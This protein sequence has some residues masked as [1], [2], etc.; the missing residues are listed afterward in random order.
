VY[1]V[2]FYALSIDVW[3]NVRITEGLYNGGLDNRDSTVVNIRENL[4]I[5]PIIK[6]VEKNIL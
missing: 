5:I 6:F 2:I 4:P 3:N 1:V